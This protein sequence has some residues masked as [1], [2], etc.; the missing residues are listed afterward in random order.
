MYGCSSRRGAVD[1]V[2]S[3]FCDFSLLNCKELLCRLIIF[4]RLSLK[5]G[6]TGLS[7]LLR[8]DLS[9]ARIDCALRSF[10]AVLS[11][12]LKKVLSNIIACWWLSWLIYKVG[13]VTTLLFN[14]CCRSLVSLP[15]HSLL[16]IFSNY[17][18]INMS[19]DIGVFYSRIGNGVLT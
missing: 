11:L 9:W 3:F 12:S 6:E 19:F 13:W 10:S 17:S 18:S 8:I 16:I 1:Y 15:G 7:W 4:F 2:F 14:L 5:N